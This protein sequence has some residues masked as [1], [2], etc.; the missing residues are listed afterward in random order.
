MPAGSGKLLSAPR[1]NYDFDESDRF[2]TETYCPV[3]LSVRTWGLVH[4][5]KAPEIAAH[6]VTSTTQEF[7]VAVSSPE[8]ALAI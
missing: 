7:P 8:N 4:C 6:S 5:V 1:S 2:D 3:K